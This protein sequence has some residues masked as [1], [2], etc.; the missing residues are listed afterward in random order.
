MTPD[1]LD[2]EIR[3]HYV[4]FRVLPDGRLCGVARLM[5]H[6]TMH[7]DID[8]VGYADRYCYET[9][10][11]AIKALDAWSGK[12]DPEGWHRHLKSGRRRNLKTGE[13]WVAP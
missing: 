8:A 3:E 1:D 7:V 2:A 6:W 5:F 12:G 4:Y 9:L 10:D 13:E 11:G